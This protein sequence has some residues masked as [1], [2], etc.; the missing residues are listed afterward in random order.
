MLSLVGGLAIQ[1]LRGAPGS[2]SRADLGVRG[3]V[4][5]ADAQS[6]E[7]TFRQG[8]DFYSG[9]TDA[10][11]SEEN[12]TRNFANEDLY[13]GMRGRVAS[14]VRFDVS[15]IPAQVI[16]QEATLGLY[17]YQH[18]SRPAE[19]SLN[20]AFVVNR[21]WDEATAT[22]RQATSLV[23]WGQP[24]CAEVPGDRSGTALDAQELYA[25]G[26][27][28]T[29]DVRSAAQEWVSN[30]DGNRGL[31]LQQTNVAVGGEYYVRS[32]ESPSVE[33]RPY[34]YVRY[35]HPTPTPT[36]TST[37]TPT[38]TPTR[39]STPTITPTFTPTIYFLY[40]PVVIKTYPRTC[41]QPDSVFQEEFEGPLLSGWSMDMQEGEHR[42]WDSVLDLW[43]HPFTDKFPVLWRNDAFEGTGSEL[44]MEVR[45]RYSDVTAHGTTI[46]VNT[47]SY[48][49][50]R[51]PEYQGLPPGV[52]DS[53]SIHNV[54]DPV[55]AIFRFDVSLLGGLVKWQGTPGDSSWHVVRI[56]LQD[57]GLYTLYVDGSRIGSAQ[58]SARPYSVYVGNPRTPL[59]AG[60][61]TKLHVDYIRVS[62]CLEWGSF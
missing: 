36:N 60:P 8:V 6:F 58:S 13:L 3:G 24:G 29:W 10:R 1:P 47:A 54:V 30:P 50:E 46:A 43:T 18:G 20:A 42:I 27:W 11:I 32:S 9:C 61:W 38:V 62:R 7:E 14:L 37:P 41:V 22:W 25:H 40:L 28:Y 23:Q 2:L 26:Q 31:L 45:F 12:P 34:L 4:A 59:G 19:A 48:E 5:A 51:F 52:E 35:A 53:L 57:A 56:Q 15:S 39:T 44:V 55:R 16:V 33:L 17:V 21:P 49:G